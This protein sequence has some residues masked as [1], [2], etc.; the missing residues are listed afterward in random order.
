[1]SRR[2]R[3]R[4]GSTLVDPRTNALPAVRAGLERA[5]PLMLLVPFILAPSTA[6]RIFKTFLCDNIQYDAVNGR[7]RRYLRADL[8]LSCDGADY[9]GTRSVALVFLF[10]WPVGTPVLYAAL[11]FASRD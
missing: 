4:K 8:E 11:L 6:A 7:T 2:R 1:M 5:T 3:R 9:Q 10:C